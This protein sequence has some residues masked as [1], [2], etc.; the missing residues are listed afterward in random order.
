MHRQGV[1]PG[2]RRSVTGSRECCANAKLFRGLN[3]D[4]YAGLKI[5]VTYLPAPPSP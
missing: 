4:C 3:A 2:I 1:L 5:T